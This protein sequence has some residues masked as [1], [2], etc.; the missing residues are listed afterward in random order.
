MG[1][2]LVDASVTRD[3]PLPSVVP[4]KLTAITANVALVAVPHADTTVVTVFASDA[5]STATCI[6]YGCKGPLHY[7]HPIAAAPRTTFMQLFTGLGAERRGAICR[8]YSSFREAHVALLEAMPRTT[9]GKKHV[10]RRTYAQY[11]VA[12]ALAFFCC[13]LP[14]SQLGNDTEG[15]H[16]KA[17]HVYFFPGSVFALWVMCLRSTMFS[18]RDALNKGCISKSRRRCTDQCT[19]MCEGSAV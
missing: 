5:T 12:Y 6:H 13:G 3:V 10:L 19:E 9:S 8:D 15:Q 16:T 7:V 14:V 11:T 4:P 2:P 18:L 1:T 17:K